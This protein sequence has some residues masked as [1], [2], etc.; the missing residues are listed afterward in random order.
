V[1]HVDGEPVRFGGVDPDGLQ[2]L[3]DDGGPVG[4]V[5]G[6]GLS[7]PRRAAQVPG[8]SHCR[9]TQFGRLVNAQQLLHVLAPL[10]PCCPA[11]GWAVSSRDRPR[12]VLRSNAVQAVGGDLV[13]IAYPCRG[14]PWALEC[15]R[16]LSDTAAE[17]MVRVKTL[18]AHQGGAI[19]WTTPSDV[20]PPGYGA[21]CS[22]GS[23]V[24][25]GRGRRGPTERTPRGFQPPTVIS[26]SAWSMSS[27]AATDG[28]EEVAL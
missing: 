23:D 20:S 4:A 21:E 5:L 16:V 9:S 12:V 1:K 14:T 22:V 24:V 18:G 8:E 6:Q 15:S 2:D 10:P 19:L 11:A 17:E 7:A 27:R 13:H 28:A 25:R 26:R 3:A